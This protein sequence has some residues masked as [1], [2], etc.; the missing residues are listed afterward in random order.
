MRLR[1]RVLA[2]IGVTFAGLVIALYF[3]LSH[4]L[5]SSFAKVEEKEVAENVERVLHAFGAEMNTTDTLVG[6]WAGWDDTVEYISTRRRRYADS[7]LSAGSLSGIGHEA[8]AIVDNSG[9][10][11]FGRFIDPERGR[12]MPLSRQFLNHV[13]LGGALSG[14]KSAGERASGFL[15]SDGALWQ[16][17]SRPV[18]NSQR[19][20]RVYGT[21]LMGRRL[22]SS[23]VQRIGSTTGFGV[24]LHAIEPA[25]ADPRL[26]K[27]VAALRR[28]ARHYFAPLNDNV[29]AGFALIS[30]IYG[31]QAIVLEVRS[32][33]AVYREGALSLR[34]ALASVAGA[35]ALFALLILWLIDGAVI[36]RLTRLAS[37]LGRISAAR[38]AFGR[39]RVDGD[40]ELGRLA[41]NINA[42]L[43]D[44]ERSHFI[45]T[46]MSLNA[47][48]A[49]LLVDGRTSECRW[50][51]QAAAMLGCSPEAL[52]AHVD[53]LA[54]M[55]DP[56]DLRLVV[57]LHDRSCETGEPFRAECRILLADGS[58]GTWA[59]RGRPI[60]NAD[61]S[62]DKFLVACTDVT[63]TR[64]REEELRASQERLARIVETNTNGTLFLDVDGRV[65]LAN[66]AAEEILGLS[67]E[68]LAGRRCDDL[69]WGGRDVQGEPV[70]RED[71][72]FEVVLRTDEPV[73][74]TELMLRHPSGRNV[75]VSINAGPLHDDNG[76][77]IGVVMSIND[78]TVSRMLQE[79]LSYQA[80]HDALTGLPNRALLLDRLAK[81]LQRAERGDKR[82][83]VLF[84][85]LDNFKNINDTLG[86][87]VGDQ[88]L[89]AVAQR[90]SHCLR[91]GDTA[92]RFGG[93]E[94]A[95]VAEEV[96]SPEEALDIAT[97]VAAEMHRPFDLG[98]REVSI[99]PS[100]GVS[101][102]RLGESDPEEL[103]RNAD[104]A[105]Y[106][107]KHNGKNRCEVFHAG[108][109]SRGLQRIELEN[110]LRRALLN[111]EYRLFFQPRVQL[112]D[113]GIE[114]MEAL[115]R[116]SHPERGIVSPGEFIPAAEQCDVIVP[117]GAWV[118]REAC[119]TAR[120]WHDVDPGCGWT[121]SVNLSA[122]QFQQ[123]DLADLVA[124]TLAETGLEPR[125]LVL[126]ITESVVMAEAESTVQRLRTLKGL[127][128]QLAI[129]DFGTGY[130]SLTYLKKYPIDY[131]KID[132]TFVS[133]LDAG[134]D[135]GVIVSATV[136]LAHALGM[137]I[138]AEGAE[139]TE[140]VTRLKRLG[141]DLAQGYWFARPCPPDEIDRSYGPAGR[142]QVSLTGVV[143]A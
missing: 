56:E 138:V 103:L 16:V 53:A 62:L 9:R 126:E 94:F 83:A 96:V 84:L 7:N 55:V 63:E 80:F 123:P 67:R 23:D 106:E 91:T 120:T 127:G 97:R 19:T 27:P 51:G 132:R 39:V 36:R 33:R 50:Y 134:D 113:G 1:T 46:Q 10:L 95:V 117:I 125:Y 24:S 111:G 59:V 29:D 34:S 110:D 26:A 79:R 69:L 100:I 131:V 13:T 8:I 54:A 82:V 57:S 47:T 133:T 25:A 65:T 76:A 18:T 85:D 70:P 88:L 98:S 122:R 77:V 45:Q 86:H 38:D 107:A 20:G 124:R 112:S 44:L 137:K 81:A 93:D 129:D 35:A 30:D 140:Q 105:M 90:L 52:P 12:T 3:A 21:L 5:V 142:G 42:V 87:A 92:A 61:G 118:L 108:L 114:G 116:W 104:A 48:D 72:P 32:Q 58:T 17:S 130:S 40:D 128:V 68:Q 78:V 74:G 143:G 64:R 141:C 75:I 115:L 14:F 43:A 2:T 102:S 109:H 73:C 60:R 49:L 139:R 101:L 135:D 4:I 31:R 11:V 121:V 66:A 71:L 15:M 89:I 119:R 22:D 6:D 37:D 28:G 99:S 41:R 136:S